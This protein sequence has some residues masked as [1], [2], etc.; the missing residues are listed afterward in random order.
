VLLTG[1]L[2][3]LGSSVEALVAQVLLEEPQ[4]IA[5]VIQLGGVVAV[6]SSL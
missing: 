1:H 6:A 4:A 2:A 5:R 3:I